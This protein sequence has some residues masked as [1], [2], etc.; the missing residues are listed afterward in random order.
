MA[1]KL[2]SILDGADTLLL[3]DGSIVALDSPKFL[4]WLENNSS[5]RFDC[6]LAGKDGFTARKEKSGYWYAYKK[7]DG[8]L[9]KSYIGNSDCVTIPKL[10]EV[11]EKLHN[12][13]TPRSKKQLHNGF[14]QQLH[15]SNEQLP[16]KVTESLYATI[17]NQAK[18]IETMQRALT[19][20]VERV[21]RLEAPKKPESLPTEVEVTDGYTIQLGKRV[22]E[23]E[24]LARNL[25]RE[26]QQLKAEVEQKRADLIEAYSGNVEAYDRAN[27]LAN[28]LET[29]Q[30]R[31][32]EIE[33]SQQ[34]I[35]Q[36]E[37]SQVL[38]PA[39]T[40]PEKSLTPQVNLMALE[41]FLAGL[42]LGKQSPD[43]K[44]AKRWVSRFI[45]FLTPPL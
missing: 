33:A 23:L 42:K 35:A 34:R 19:A 1:S 10:L 36:L 29:A 32:A 17:S 11:A 45:E 6:G 15:T 41:D 39:E 43:Y 38:Q 37:E 4:T 16:S 9:H 14:D 2:A 5:F 25:E 28:E 7:I 44:A 26:N 22:N 31:I 21:E 8:K 18:A 3:T 27:K 40:Q 12:P 13:S 20:L 24:A 30:Q